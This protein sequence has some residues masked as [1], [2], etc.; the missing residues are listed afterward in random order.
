MISPEVKKKIE[1]YEDVYFPFDEPVPFKKG[2]KIYPVTVRNYNKFH[3]C[4]SCLMMD[5][6][7]KMILEEN[8]RGELEE[9]KVSNPAGIS[10]SYMAYLIDQMKNSDRGELYTSQILT[11]FD[12]C[13]HEK[14]GLYCPVC[15]DKIEMVD[16]L[17]KFDSISL[18]NK[19]EETTKK[20]FAIFLNSMMVCPKCKNKRREYISIEENGRASKFCIGNYKFTSQDF[21]EFKSIITHQ[22]ILGYDG[23]EYIDPDLK[24]DL[25]LKAKLENKDY[26]TPS[27]EKQMVCITISSPYTFDQIKEL[28][29]RKLSFLLKTIDQK[30]HY[31]SQLQGMYSGMVKFKEDPK[32]WIFSDNKKDL[33]KEIMTMKQLRDKFKDVT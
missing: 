12:L 4:L 11:L 32:H 6:N 15:N 8:E 26:S 22:N 1:I 3:N 9:K 20:N 27:I 18:E 30:E 28:S 31:F 7:S 16:I 13:L 17:Q 24:A 5:K 2:L 10:M 25:E 23:D 29:L 14:N 21:E 33:S 19:D